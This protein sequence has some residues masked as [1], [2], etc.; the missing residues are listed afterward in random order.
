M[1][2]ET[3]RDIPHLILRTGSGRETKPSFAPNGQLRRK[4]GSLL[5]RKMRGKVRLLGNK[6]SSAA[7]SIQKC[8]WNG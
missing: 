8:E 7:K 6:N 1:A 2:S 3:R 4:K 5:Q